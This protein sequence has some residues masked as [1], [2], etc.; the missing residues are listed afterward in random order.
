[1]HDAAGIPYKGLI[2]IEAQLLLISHPS[3]DSPL[4]LPRPIPLPSYLQCDR[5]LQCDTALPPH[6]AYRAGFS[7]EISPLSSPACH[8][9]AT[10]AVLMW[11]LDLLIDKRTGFPHLEGR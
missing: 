10:S 9:A 2:S 7:G 4:C 1:M 5:S 3:I 11:L 8:L 6:L